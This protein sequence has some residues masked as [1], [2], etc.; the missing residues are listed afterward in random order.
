MYFFGNVVNPGTFIINGN[1]VRP[2]ETVKLLGV[3]IDNKLDFGHHVSHICQKAGKQVIMNLISYYCT[4]HLY[5]ATSTTAVFY[6][7]SAIT[8]IL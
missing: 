7:I 8:L 5:H 6:G 3:H 4:A 1:I 2:E